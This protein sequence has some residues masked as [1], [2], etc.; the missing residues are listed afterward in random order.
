MKELTRYQEKKIFLKKKNEN[1]SL[2][3]IAIG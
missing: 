1:F 3:K 2:Q